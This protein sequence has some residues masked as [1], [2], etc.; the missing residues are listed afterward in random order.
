MVNRIFS[1]VNRL[2]SVK[3]GQFT[4]FA[5]PGQWGDTLNTVEALGCTLADVLHLVDDVK[6]CY[7]DERIF[8]RFL[9]S[10]SRGLGRGR[11]T[12]EAKLRQER[13]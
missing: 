7:A 12:R 6:T 1:I 11:L 13:L 2:D 5:P 4:R 8:T 10:Y 3:Y 9:Q